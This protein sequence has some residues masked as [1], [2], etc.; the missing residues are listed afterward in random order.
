MPTD[1]DRNLQ[2][3][4]R[5]PRE[6]LSNEIK[7]WLDPTDNEHR[8]HVAKACIALANHGGGHLIIGLTADGDGYREADARLV[9]DNDVRHG[10]DQRQQASD[11]GQ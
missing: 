3:L 11:I 7:N 10:T 5:D 6:T 1:I 4:L 9:A 8:A 2:D